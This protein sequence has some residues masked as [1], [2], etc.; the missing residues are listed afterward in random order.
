MGGIANIVAVIVDLGV[1]VHVS[2][3]QILSLSQ[4]LWPEIKSLL[5]RA[6]RL[7]TTL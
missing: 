2:L 5:G 4:E 7:K 1:K 3:F 6:K